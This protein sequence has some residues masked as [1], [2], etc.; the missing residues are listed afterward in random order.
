MIV[1]MND[2][3]ITI[4]RLAK[5]LK[6]DIRWL[7]KEVDAGHIPHLQ[8]GKDT[9]FNPDAVRHELIKRAQQNKRKLSQ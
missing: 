4:G 3:L 5:L 9:L 1:I 6:V 7:R 8:A 2:E